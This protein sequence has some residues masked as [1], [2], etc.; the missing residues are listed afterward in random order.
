MSK[1]K[2]KISALEDAPEGL[3]PFYVKQEDGTFL[4][5]ID[6][7]GEITPGMLRELRAQAKA[8]E[9]EKAALAKRLE[10]YKD[11]DPQKYQAGLK[12]LQNVEDENERK[13]LVEGKYEDVF[14]AR[15]SKMQASHENEVAKL[16]ELAANHEKSVKEMRQKLGRMKLESELMSAI[17]SSGV[18]V[19]KGAM[20]DLVSRAERT[21]QI[22]D[23]GNPVPRDSQGG[24]VRGSK[25]EPLSMGEFLS[26]L[27]SGDGAFLFAQAT[28]G[29]ATGSRAPGG[30]PKVSK[31]N[32][33]DMARYASQIIKGEVE[34]VD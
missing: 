1:P 14:K 23:E 26:G 25:G 2:R 31:S 27:A 5:D 12:L 10:Q 18:K 21:Y 29:N 13:L 20:V 11:V 33:R 7:D 28:G 4:F 3:R 32:A 8:A 17:N 9:D 30:K 22:D 19:Q 34:V 16:R 24:I 6:G 15:V